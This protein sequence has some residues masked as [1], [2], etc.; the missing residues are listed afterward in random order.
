MVEICIINPK[1]VSMV[2]VN[3]ELLLSTRSLME[4]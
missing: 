2:S 1:Q 4:A 3:P